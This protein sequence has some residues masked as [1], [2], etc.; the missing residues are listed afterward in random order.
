MTTIPELAPILQTLL[1]T[2]A[3]E[4]ARQSGFIQRQRLITGSQFVQ[5]LVFSQLAHP[6]VTYRQIHQRAIALGQAISVQALD[7]RLNQAA[8]GRFLAL[9][10]DEAMRLA[11]TG[12]HRLDLLSRFAG[13]YI[14]DGSIVRFGAERRKLGAM[15]E[16]Q[17]GTLR[18]CMTDAN[19]NDQV[20]P[21]ML[22]E[23]QTKQLHLRDLGF[24]KLSTFATWNTQQVF[25]LSR[26]KL[27]VK[28]YDAETG[29][30]IR[31]D[32]LPQGQSFRLA[33]RMGEQRVAAYLVGQATPVEALQKRQQRLRRQ[34]Q[35]EQA[36][37][38]EQR[39][40]FSTWTLYLTNI[41]DLTFEQAHT[42]ARLRWQI[43]LLFKLWKYQGAL[44]NSRSEIP[45]RNACLSYAKLLAVLLQ[46]WLLIVTGWQDAQQSW[47]YNAGVLR[48]EVS[49]L[50][51]VLMDIQALIAFL[52]KLAS[53]FQR[54]FRLSKRAKHPLTFQL[55]H[56]HFH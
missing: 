9:M 4:L 29:H 40:R 43:E 26:L 49:L 31:L 1:G 41:P 28:L 20:L 12:D 51:H 21:T 27:Q 37:I 24:F 32:D 30:E 53:C 33:V 38:S 34:A 23:A 19:R 50:Q 48:D 6:L 56:F 7:K 39:Q 45:N 16:L 44:E 11:I 46:H 54:A 22:P 3:N 55:F 52:E 15:L 18:L 10:L 42:L 8:S 14:T 13:V 47:V 5:T 25:W 35:L 17:T 36:P 2:R